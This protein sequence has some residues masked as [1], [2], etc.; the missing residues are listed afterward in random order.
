MTYQ[1]S[2][3]L[4]L[5]LKNFASLCDDE[6][7]I[8]FIFASETE[9]EMKI[10]EKAP[11]AQYAMDLQHEAFY[12]QGLP[13]AWIGYCKSE[14]RIIF[15]YRDPNLQLWLDQYT[16]EVLHFDGEE[17]TPINMDEVRKSFSALLKL[18]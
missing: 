16:N 10:F 13:L 2:F 11:D 9:F 1:E 6:A 4:A 8:C 17:S 12:I 5:R 7:N 18:K 14:N 15:D 3:A